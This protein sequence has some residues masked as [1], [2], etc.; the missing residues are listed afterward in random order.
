[1]KISWVISDLAI[2]DPTINI[3]Q[4]KSIGSFWG[5]WRNWRSCQIDNVICNDMIKADE[6]IKRNFQT[7][8]NFYISNSIYTSLGSPSGVQIFEGKFIH[9][10]DRQEEIIAMHLSAS[11]SDIVLLFGFDFREALPNP[12]RLLEHRAHNYHNLIKEAIKSNAKV[13]WVV[14]D[15]AEPI[16]PDYKML[17]NL[18]KDNLANVIKLLN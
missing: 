10:V 6:L 15:H 13:Q 5:S 17:T 14:I 1:M 16:M 11:T 9:D 7:L 4:L 2:V 12:N 18:T 3:D 8:C